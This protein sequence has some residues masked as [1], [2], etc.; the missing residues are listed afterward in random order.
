M[1]GY[2]VPHTPKVTIYEKILLCVRSVMDA[3]LS[4][5]SRMH[6]ENVV[7]LGRFGAKTQK[8]CW[9]FLLFFSSTSKPNSDCVFESSRHC[10]V[11]F[12]KDYATM[13]SVCQ[14][15]TK[16]WSVIYARVFIFFLISLMISSYIN[17]N[18]FLRI[19]WCLLIFWQNTNTSAWKPR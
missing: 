17:F 13:C 1:L 14:M 3:S 5:L 10:H 6:I 9:T 2:C 19:C 12:T 18:K 4:F 8:D 15:M 7:K 11:V 16:A